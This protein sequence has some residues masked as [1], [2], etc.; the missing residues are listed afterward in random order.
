MA[1]MHS[2]RFLRRIAMRV[3]FHRTGK[4]QYRVVVVI[5]GRPP[6]EMNSAPGYDDLM[7]HDL[8]HFIVERTLG[9][10]NGIFGQ[11]AHGGSAGTFHHENPG[12]AS[13]RDAK[14]LKRKTETFARA[15]REDSLVSERAT[16][17]AWQDWLQSHKSADARARGAEMRD[18][19]Q[20][21]LSRIGKEERKLY[22]AE[23]L[24]RLRAV[25]EEASEEWQATLIGGFIELGW[26]A[27]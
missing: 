14:A 16:Y 3:Q 19:A 8:Q 2:R 5:P 26:E 15:G 24:A 12:E 10:R 23:N 6:L 25:M 13:K 21:I 4:R 7:P 11:L 9:I 18:T 17:I 20:S 22:S 27:R 1:I